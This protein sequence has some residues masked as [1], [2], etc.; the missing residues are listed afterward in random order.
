MET[1]KAQKLYKL[2]WYSLNAFFSELKNYLN[3]R[4]KGRKNEKWSKAF[5][6]RYFFYFFI[7]FF[8]FLTFFFFFNYFFQL[9]FPFFFFFFSFFSIFLIIIFYS[10]TL[11]LNQRESLIFSK[12]SLNLGD[13]TWFKFRVIMEDNNTPWWNIWPIIALKCRSNAAKY[14]KNFFLH[15]FLFLYFSIIIT[16]INIPIS[17]FKRFIFFL[18]ESDSHFL[19]RENFGKRLTFSEVNAK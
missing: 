7:I 2:R 9:F 18:K 13:S 3:C 17:G 12:N 19:M 5:W 4:F 10:R 14:R 15:S 11:N 16:Q 6:I 8:L 1:Q